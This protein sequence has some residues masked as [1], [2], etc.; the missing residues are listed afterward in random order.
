MAASPSA[1]P[2]SV[3]V[4]LHT[5][6]LEP[7]EGSN[8]SARLPQKITSAFP[9]S[10]DPSVPLSYVPGEPAVGLTSSEV[11]GFLKRELA[12]PL[13]DEL[14]PRLW[15]SARRSGASIDPLHRQTIKGRNIVP[16]EDPHLHLVW[17]PDKIYVKPIPV[18]LFNHQFWATYLSSLPTRQRCENS[19]P[20]EKE[21]TASF[22]PSIP[23]GFLRS[24]AYLIQHRLDFIIACNNHLIPKDID[25]TQWSLFI[26]NFRTIGDGQVARRYHYGQLRLSRLNWAVRIFRPRNAAT[27]W[28]YEL[29]FW[30]IRSYIQWAIT[31]LAFILASVSLVLSSMQVVTS[32]PADGLGFASLGGP[33]ILALR[34]ACWVFSIMILLISGIIWTLLLV[35]PLSVLI[36]QLSWGYKNR[37]RTESIVGGEML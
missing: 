21:I 30:S 3:T 17:H 9:R 8:R 14:Y 23:T 29:P 22:D 24:Y 7:S 2:F 28:F 25:W 6:S 4:A 16:T 31:P 15:L 27:W 26:S 1:P 11:L 13:L 32:I 5:K 12:T 10:S 36:W 18:C 19:K 33:G 20:K 37:G 34:R 35:I